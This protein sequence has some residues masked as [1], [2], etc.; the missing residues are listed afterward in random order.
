MGRKLNKL[1]ILFYDIKYFFNKKNIIEEVLT[2]FSISGKYWKEAY[3]KL[4]EDYCKVM[5][6]VTDGMMS[7]KH[8]RPEDILSLDEERIN[9]IIYKDRLEQLKK[10]MS[11]VKDYPTVSDVMIA[12]DE[13]IQEAEE[14]YEIYKRGN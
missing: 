14:G 2:K 5:Y 6:E 4:L 12:L 7:Y 13:Y 9:R 11:E 3:Y 10:I 8:Y 1:E